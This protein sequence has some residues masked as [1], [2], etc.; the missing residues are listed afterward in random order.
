MLAHVTAPE[1]DELPASLSHR[2]TTEL[3][4]EELGFGGIIVTDAMEMG[5]IVNTW[6]AGESAVMAI[7]AGADI[8]LCP[9]DLDAAVNAVLSAVEEGRIPRERLEESARRVLYLKAM[10]GILP[11]R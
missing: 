9:E 2:I 6:G 11:G 7:E 4:R 5:A 3:L 1:L 8:I 10:E